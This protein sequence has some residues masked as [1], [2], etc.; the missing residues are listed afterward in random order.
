M[1]VDCEIG[2]IGGSI[3]G[4]SIAATFQEFEQ[5]FFFLEKSLNKTYLK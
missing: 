1:E 4:F 3:F 2:R 5:K